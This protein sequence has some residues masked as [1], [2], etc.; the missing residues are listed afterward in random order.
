MLGSSFLVALTGYG[1][2]NE[3]IL[4]LI[5]LVVLMNLGYLNVGKKR[6]APSIQATVAYRV[7]CGCTST[8]TG[9]QHRDTDDASSS[10]SVINKLAPYANIK[11]Q[12]ES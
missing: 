12:L 7:W 4:K 6:P 8:T 3:P 1:G 11:Q 5:F 2:N 10:S 9:A